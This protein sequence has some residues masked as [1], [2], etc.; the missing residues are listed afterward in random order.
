ME[1]FQ[2]KYEAKP[3]FPGWFFLGRGEG[4]AGEGAETK[5]PSMGGV[6]LFSGKTQCHAWKQTAV[7]PPIATHVLQC[8]HLTI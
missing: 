5:K 1:G 2:G 6:W 3:E 7:L 8:T 4:V